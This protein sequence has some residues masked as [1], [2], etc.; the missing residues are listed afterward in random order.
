MG[1]SF[2]IPLPRR[3]CIVGLWHQASVLAACFA[4][5]G[6]H[7][8]I[9][10][11]DE[12]TVRGL[13]R[14]KAPVHEPKLDAMLRRNIKAGRLR[15]TS[16]YYL[17]LADAEFV[18]LSIDTPVTTEDEPDL[19]VLHSAVEAIAA[20]RS[21]PIVLCVTAQVPVG[22]SEAFKATIQSR[23]PSHRCEVAYIPEFLRLGE[24]ITTF[25]RADRFVIGGDS[26]D[27]AARVTA[28]YEP[29]RRPILQ[30]SL[31]SAEMAKHA[32]NT[33]LAL[34]ISFINE[35]ADICERYSADAIEVA[36]AMKLDRRIGS[37]AF[38]TPGMG[39]AGGTLGR[40]VRAL[41][42][43]GRASDTPTRMADA[44]M[45]VNR[46]RSGLVTRRLTTLLGNLSGRKICIW[47]LTYKPGTSTLRRSLAL[48]VIAELNRLQAQVTAFDPLA[49]LA[50]VDL[51]SFA[52]A[53]DPYAAAA[54]ADA[55]VLMTEW[56]GIRDT[57]WGRVREAVRGPVFLDTRNIFSPFEMTR[58]GFEYFGV[59]RGG[60]SNANALAAKEC[61]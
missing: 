51:P 32:S 5:I 30:I 39:F 48:E 7:V 31:R 22:T 6:H 29:L 9:V 49:D 25:F 1:R 10:G 42:Q 34:S 17:A 50:G 53:S 21:G 18:F 28:L 19:R 58:Y 14:G 46:S 16:D 56:A 37:F 2:S 40:D 23:Q 27:V 47:G 8:T 45:A 41:Q 52:S 15:V 33:F 55:I 59:G 61:W 11:D 43:L 20:A 35:I 60:G 36:A 26:G 24:A 38:L 12:A 57:Q 3:I 54:G 44:V 13:A 4:E